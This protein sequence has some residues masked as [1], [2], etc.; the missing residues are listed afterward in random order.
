[1]K[2]L[3]FFTSVATFLVLSPGL[4][5]Q[6]MGGGDMQAMMEAAQKAQAC[7][8]KLDQ[9]SFKKME[10]R[11]R[12]IEAELK[13]LCSAGK[14]AEAMQKARK[15]AKEFTQSP[16]MQEMQ[17]CASIMDGVMDRSP[18]PDFEEMVNNSENS[19]VCDDI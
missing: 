15:Y 2:T 8:E 6:G 17:K 9:S 3:A 16:E 18:I 14:R 7:F 19:H 1:M 4:M 12:A 11:G 10:T 5:A 13:G